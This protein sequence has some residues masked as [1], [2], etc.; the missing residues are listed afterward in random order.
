MTLKE[1][2]VVAAFALAVAFP[3]RAVYVVNSA[4]D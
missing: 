4:G 2:I 3:A 1:R